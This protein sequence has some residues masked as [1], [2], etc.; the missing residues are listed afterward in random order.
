MK[1]L[2]M[3]IV[4]LL[5]ILVVGTFALTS[6]SSEKGTVTD[7]DIFFI[8]DTYQVHYLSE[9]DIFKGDIKVKLTKD[10]VKS[11]DGFYVMSQAGLNYEEYYYIVDSEGWDFREKSI[12]KFNEYSSKVE[13][14]QA[15]HATGARRKALYVKKDLID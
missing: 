10:D 9:F 2:F 6:C 12:S 15:I 1:K 11:I 3:K 5:V 8:D 14:N 4:S 13:Y 7:E